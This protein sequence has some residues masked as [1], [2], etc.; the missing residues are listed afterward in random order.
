MKLAE[1]VCLNAFYLVPLDQ[2]IDHHAKS[3]DSLVNTLECH[4]YKVITMNLAK[5]V[6]LNDF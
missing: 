5:N 2:N 6:Y 1:N 3:K 4:I